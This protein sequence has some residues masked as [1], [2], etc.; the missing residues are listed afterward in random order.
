[1]IEELIDIAFRTS[2]PRTVGAGRPHYR[3]VIMAV[4]ERLKDPTVEMC[5]AGLTASVNNAG[6]VE[7]VF[8]AMVEEAMRVDDG[9]N[10]VLWSEEVR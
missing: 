8:V 9:S 2:T 10:E 6:D 4:L 7:S 3:A 1:M 5:D